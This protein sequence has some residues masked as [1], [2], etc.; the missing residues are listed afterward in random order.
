MRLV[1]PGMSF[2]RWVLGVGEGSVNCPF[3]LGDTQRLGVEVPQRYLN[4]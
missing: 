2:A 4:N 3:T 1:R